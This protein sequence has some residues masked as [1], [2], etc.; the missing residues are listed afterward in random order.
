M[1]PKPGLDNLKTLPERRRYGRK[2]RDFLRS[3]VTDAVIAE[4]KR[5]PPAGQRSEALER[6]MVYFQREAVGDG[7]AVQVIKPF[8][9]YRLVETARRPGAEPRPLD[10][11][12]YATPDE[13][14][15][16]LF[17]RRIDDLFET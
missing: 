1:I 5:R 7:Y 15:H 3:L 8:E 13:A 10:D 11:R 9:A 17:L 14:G 2:Q 4:H 12:I 16:G 6:L